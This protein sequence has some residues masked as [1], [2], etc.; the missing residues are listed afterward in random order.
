MNA[1]IT[2]HDPPSWDAICWRDQNRPEE[3]EGSTAAVGQT[4]QAKHRLV[5]MAMELTKRTIAGSTQRRHGHRQALKPSPFHAIFDNCLSNH[6]YP[7][8]TCSEVCS[9][10]HRLSLV[11][12]D[13]S[14]N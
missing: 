6:Q 14:Q 7:S 9:H 2:S 10:A 5:L 12:S 8:A 11:L 13:I 4:F 1:T 3:I